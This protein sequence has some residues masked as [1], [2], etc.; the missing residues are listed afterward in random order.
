MNCNNAQKVERNLFLKKLFNWKLEILDKKGFRIK[1]ISF[2]NV[3]I[4]KE[5][6]G[7]EFLS[8]T[9]IV[10]FPYLCNLQE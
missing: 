5:N 2:A 8:Q 1:I 4:R 9:E 7:T 10:W 6:K 3:W